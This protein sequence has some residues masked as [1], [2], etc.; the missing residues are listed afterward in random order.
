MRKV[1]AVIGAAV[2]GAGC[3]GM[4]PELAGVLGSAGAPAP[5][6]EHEIAQGLKEALAVGTERAVGRIGVRDGFWLNSAVNIPLPESLRKVE[7]TLR[8]FG[9]GA[10]VD[11]FHL[12]LNRA[13]EAAVPE[14]AAIFGDAIR[15]MT[16]ADARQILNGPSNAA[17]DYFRGKTQGA[18][19]QRFK[20]TVSKATA[21]V[22]ATRKYKELSAKVT[23]VMPG[24]EL[25]DIDGYVTD[26]ALAGLFRTLADEELKIRQDPAAR[27]TELMKRVF[28]S[29]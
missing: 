20:P 24:Y 18:L 8:T 23:K 27:T 21:S 15:A 29:R 12:S 26:R 13:A 25:Q 19:T 3:A 5:L 14:A 11:E 22:G 10:R 9:Q 6:A 2:L 17:T 7:K 28:G 4:P 16:L 1:L